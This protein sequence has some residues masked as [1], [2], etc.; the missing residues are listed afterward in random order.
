MKRISSFLILSATLA[1]SGL[2]FAQ[3]ASASDLALFQRYFGTMDY[4]VTG[5]GGIRSTGILDVGH[6]NEFLAAGRIVVSNSDLPPNADLVAAFIYWQT[7]EKT[8]LPASARAY[9][10]YATNPDSRVKIL[11]KPL[12]NGETAR[13]WSNGGSTGS[14]NGAGTVR[15]Y[16]A[17]VMRYLKDPTTGQIGRDLTIRVRDSGSTGNSVPLAEGASLVLVYRHPALSF[18]SI[19]IFDGTQ[20][21]NNQRDSMDLVIKGFDQASPGSAKITHIVGNGQS[22]FPERLYFNGQEIGNNPFVNGW[23][24]LTTDVTN[25]VFLNAPPNAIVNTANTHV[26]HDPGSF[27]C[28]SWG[29]VVFSTTVQD[30]DQDG[31]LDVWETD[32]FKDPAGTVLV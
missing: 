23:D 24:N 18:K 6:T 14:S 8:T 1:L 21:M 29:A 9:L 2:L 16:R 11:G 13:C 12:G 4:S 19:E 31:L 30:T 26:G 10:S 25:K 3:S 15:V 17:D 20:T 32:G 7:L 28:L 27:D 5:T 22:N